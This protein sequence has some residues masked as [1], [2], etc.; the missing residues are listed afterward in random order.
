MRLSLLL[1]APMVYGAELH[2]GWN[3]LGAEQN[4]YTQVLKRAYIKIVWRYE[5]GQWYAF[6][7]DRANTNF[8]YIPKKRGFWVL[9]TKDTNISFE[10]QRGD[11][12]YWQLQ[13]K[14]DMTKS[15]KVYDIDLFD[16]PKSVIDEL[17]E[18]NKVVICY[19][20]AGSYEAWRSDSAD[21]P[22]E[23]IGK[24][25]DGW[26]D[27][28][29]LDITHPKIAQIMMGR[30]DLAAQ[31]GCDGVEADNV[32]VYMH[33]SGFDID[34]QKQLA[35][36]L[37]LADEAHKRGLLIGLK[38]DMQQIKD[39]A[40]RFDFAVNEECFEYDECTL[41]EPFLSQNKAVLNAEYKVDDI[42]DEAKLLGISSA[43]YTK[44]LD[45]SFYQPCF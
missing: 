35:Y 20:S 33:K 36:N 29:W 30:L 28:R 45:G 17:H 26:Q 27:E 5:K 7:P 18:K 14:I 39:L 32:D 2:T 24:S 19:F 23:A 31:K 6:R 34:Y 42:C 9:S 22:K 25:L 16:T 3:L 12:W 10:I 38:N 21:F 44:E 37:F 8:G 40:T 1:L 43:F 41:Y 15:A 13:G 4:I 11:S